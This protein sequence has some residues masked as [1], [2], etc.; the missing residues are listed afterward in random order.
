VVR[1]R[2]RRLGREYPAGGVGGE[3]DG[4]RGGCLIPNLR[5]RRASR[6]E[7]DPITIYSEQ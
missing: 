1:W 6:Q 7:G 5:R 2:G 4:T 3:V